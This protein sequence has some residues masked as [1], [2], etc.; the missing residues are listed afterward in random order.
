[1][2]CRAVAPR[3][4]TTLRSWSQSWTRRWSLA[5][6]ASRAQ[7]KEGGESGLDEKRAHLSERHAFERLPR[8]A[9]T[10]TTTTSSNTRMAYKQRMQMEESDAV[11]SPSHT[12]SHGSR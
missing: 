12:W 2:W 6:H 10:M 5:E 1:M 4:K 9:D 11:E 7:V 8:H 3:V